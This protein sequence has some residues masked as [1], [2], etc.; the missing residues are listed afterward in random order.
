M[1]R[2]IRRVP[3]GEKHRRRRN[4]SNIDPSPSCASRALSKLLTVRTAGR[5]AWE[6]AKCRTI[7]AVKRN[8]C[9]ETTK[10]KKR[11]KGKKRKSIEGKRDEGSNRSTGRKRSWGGWL[12]FRQFRESLDCFVEPSVLNSCFLGSFSFPWGK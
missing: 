1:H 11:K 7:V 8:S 10:K 2:S 9:M 4:G 5:V 3:P 12:S 6:R